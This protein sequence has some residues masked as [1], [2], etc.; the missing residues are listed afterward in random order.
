MKLLRIRD[1]P[2]DKYTLA[3]LGYNASEEE[4]PAIELTYNYGVSSYKHDEA[5][6]HVAIGV[7]DVKALVAEL[8]AKGVPIDYE[9]EDGYMAFIVDPDGYY[10]ELLNEKMMLEKAKRM[11]AEQGRL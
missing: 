3:F 8:R 11:M 6:G 1:A 10:I 7:E 4:G 9:R 2:D 5:Y